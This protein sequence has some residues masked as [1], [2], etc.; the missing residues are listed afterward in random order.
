MNGIP[1]TFSEH[2]INR[3]ILGGPKTID[4]AA[5]NISVILLNSSGSHFKLHM[6]ENLLQCN[7]QT[8]VSV[9]HDSSNFTD[10]VSKRFPMIKFIVPLEKTSDGDLINLAMS[11]L[12]SDY[13]LV[14]RDSL[15]IPTNFIP[16][17]LAERITENSPYCIV[18]RLFDNQKNALPCAF[19]PSA[20]HTHFVI[21][22]SSEINNGKKT[23]YP[24]DYIGLYNRK[25]FIELG[26]FDWTINSP[27]WQNLDLALRSWLWGEQTLL[28]SHLQFSY[29]DEPPVNDTTY[30]LDYLRYY[31]KNELPKIKMETGYFRRS[32]FFV[33]LSRSSC[34]F[35]EARRQFNAAKVWVSKNK[36]RYK[37][38][39][40]TL[41]QSW[42]RND[43][44]K[45]K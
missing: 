6:F 35:M 9:E 44:D 42:S 18:P 16:S 40:Q 37:M 29:I 36:Y 26:G 4:P 45:D 30:N 11:E 20:E 43:E 21:D 24:F 7:F 19:T 27:Y 2:Q 32:S 22:S 23:L 31:L 33:F 25:K 17:H 5:L 3:T 13:V 34:G 8:I 28:T 39:L 14:L 10:E 15:N 12:T 38:D 41:I 1:L